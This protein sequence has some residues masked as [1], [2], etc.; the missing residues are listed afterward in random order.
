MP[1]THM[2]CQVN[3]PGAPSLHS[4]AGQLTSGWLAI[5]LTTSSRGAATMTGPSHR[6]TG[7]RGAWNQPFFRGW[8]LPSCHAKMTGTDAQL[9]KSW[10]R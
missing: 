6:R 2:T 3:C 5:Q 9:F 10:T 8:Y 4:A 7:R 1:D